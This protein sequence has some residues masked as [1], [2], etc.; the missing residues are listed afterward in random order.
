MANQHVVPNNG[1]WQVK[2]ENLTRAT[3]NFNTQITMY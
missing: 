3:K 1:Q 2:C